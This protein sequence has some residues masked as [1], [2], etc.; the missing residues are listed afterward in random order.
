MDE[1]ELILSVVLDNDNAFHYLSAKEIAIFMASCKNAYNSNILQK[2]RNKH[3]ALY[4]Y[5][6]AWYMMKDAHL[7]LH[8]Y[9]TLQDLDLSRKMFDKHR[10]IVREFQNETDDVKDCLSRILA[11]EY[12]E[13]LYDLAYDCVDISC[14]YHY[15]FL[16]EKFKYDML[17]NL[18]FCN[19]AL[20]DIYDPTHYVFMDIDEDYYKFYINIEKHG[21]NILQD[22]RCVAFIDMIEGNDSDS[23]D[24]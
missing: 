8:N 14:Y 24:A 18:S 10:D 15:R 12:K 11:A 16:L 9:R 23:S 19:N 7:T 17:Q 21:K 22:N 2:M 3:R 20:A 5:Y 13:L 1:A 4:L 6:K